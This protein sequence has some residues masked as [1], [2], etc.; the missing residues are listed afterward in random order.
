MQH[1]F[2]AKW[3]S[4]ALSQIHTRCHLHCTTIPPSSVDQ[5]W[6]DRESRIRIRGDRVRES[7]FP[8]VLTEKLCIAL[9]FFDDPH[10]FDF[11]PLS[12]WTFLFKITNRN[13]SSGFIFFPFRR[14]HITGKHHSMQSLETRNN[15]YICTSS[16][17]V[18]APSRAHAESRKVAFSYLSTIS[19]LRWCCVSV[20]E[21]LLGGM[22]SEESS[23]AVA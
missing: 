10:R 16:R 12:T 3:L 20:G 9:V 17:F 5:R 4:T 21:Q 15:V 8:Q 18:K 14:F 13:E 6:K 23:R 22:W 19:F 2:I 11:T 7:V 1:A